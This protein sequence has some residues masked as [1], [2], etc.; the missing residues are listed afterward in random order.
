MYY[1]NCFYVNVRIYQEN[2]QAN[3]ICIMVLFVKKM[4]PV[5]VSTANNNAVTCCY[6]CINIFCQSL[7]EVQDRTHRFDVSEWPKLNIFHC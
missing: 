7:I 3:Q 2:K 4:T 5:L 6:T 1:I